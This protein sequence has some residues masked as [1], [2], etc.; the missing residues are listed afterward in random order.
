MRTSSN[1]PRK[2][3]SPMLSVDMRRRVPRKSRSLSSIAS[4]RSSSGVRFHRPQRVHTTHSLPF[5]VSNANRRP[6]G[7]VGRKWLAPRSEWQKRQVVYID[8]EE[9]EQLRARKPNGEEPKGED[10][11]QR[12]QRTASRGWSLFALPRRGGRAAVLIET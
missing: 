3:A 2:R 11:E 12:R 9:R 1:P 6:T 8:A 10:N 7:K 5:F 4:H